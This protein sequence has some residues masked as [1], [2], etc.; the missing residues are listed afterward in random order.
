MTMV[1]V[2]AGLAGASAVEELREQGYDGDIT[3]LGAEPHLPY[4]RPPLSKA[5]LATDGPHDAPTLRHEA[6][7]RAELG[8]P[9]RSSLATNRT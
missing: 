6:S 9:T 7:L 4:D 1:I 5:L 8:G 3:L 2:G